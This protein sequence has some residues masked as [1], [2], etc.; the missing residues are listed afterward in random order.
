MANLGYIGEAT[1]KIIK[2]GKLKQIK[3]YKNK[4]TEALFLLLCK[5]LAQDSISSTDGNIASTL[6]STTYGINRHNLPSR[7]DIIKNDGESILFN[8]VSYIS[9]YIES[10]KTVLNF[11]LTSSSFT[12]ESSGSSNVSL[13]LLDYNGTKLAEI[14]TGASYIINKQETHRISWEMGFT[15]IGEGN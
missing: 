7:L 11:N 8:P 1:L 10:D 2:N 9:K 5:L 13:V 4:G 6:N 14:D 15:N 3:K 12:S